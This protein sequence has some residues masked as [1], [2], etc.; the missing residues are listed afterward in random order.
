MIVIP[1]VHG[2]LFWKEA[3]AAAKDDEKI[4]FLGD[5]LDPYSYEFVEDP[6]MSQFAETQE[7]R[8][9]HV[10]N[11]FKEIIEFKKKNPDRV[12][13]LLG[14]H[15][16]TYAI[17]TSICDCRRDS[18]NYKEICELFEQNKDL[19]TLAYYVKIEDKEY[20]FSH[21]GLHKEYAISVFG[22]EVKDSILTAVN[23]L[24]Y[25]YKEETYGVLD[26]LS[27][28]SWYRGGWEKTG[29]IVWADVREWIKDQSFDKGGYPL[30]Y[31]AYQ[32]FGH[33]QLCGDPIV[34]DEFA[35]LDC[36]RAF[37]FENG[38]FYELSGEEV[39]VKNLSKINN[40]MEKYFNK[41]NK[42][43]KCPTCPGGHL[44]K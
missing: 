4:I 44:L 22:K 31:D 29:S 1:D 17:S 19:F 25:H 21:S 37:R 39:P 18:I 38:K 43:G 13:L 7:T 32:I 16:C 6:S 11:N 9:N 15:D 26:S 36:R 41:T 34:T 12:V 23:E 40:Y 20:V 5:Y 14:N 3:I 30:E 2:R 42:R 24:N 8:S 27:R 10:L 33:T 35:C 28:C